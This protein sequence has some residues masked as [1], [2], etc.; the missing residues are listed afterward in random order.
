M[1]RDTVQSEGLSVLNKLIHPYIP[2]S[3]KFIEG[4]EKR[5]RDGEKE[6]RE[7]E[8]RLKISF[9]S[10]FSSRAV[11]EQYIKGISARYKDFPKSVLSLTINI[12][13]TT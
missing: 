13:R 1:T 7:E 4:V 5:N 6:V 3:Q 8:N 12:L 2:R 9:Q 10:L 11:M